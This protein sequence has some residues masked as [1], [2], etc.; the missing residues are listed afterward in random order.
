MGITHV[1]L[2][3]FLTLF[4]LLVLASVVFAQEAATSLQL[5]TP[6][7]GTLSSDNPVDLYIF[8]APDSG[9][10]SLSASSAAVPVGI[11]LTDPFGTTVG[12]VVANNSGEASLVD[13]DVDPGASY[14]V[15]VFSTDTNTGEYTLTL[16]TTDGEN[17]ADTIVDDTSDD[18]S[19]DTGTEE[20]ATAPVGNIVTSLEAPETIQ[21]N[22]GMEVR[23]EWNAAVDLN[24]EV[25]DPNGNTLFFNSRSSAI[26]GSF[27]FDANG[28]CEVISDAPV[29][30]ASW[31]PGFV[32]T[33]SYEILVF[34]R[35]DC[36]ALAQTV[37]FT[38]TVTVNGSVLPAIE[39]T[40]VP[41]TPTSSSVYLSNFIV[42]DASTA[43]LNQGGAYPDSSIQILPATAAELQT[44]AQPINFNTPIQGALF[45]EQDF[46]VYSFE[47]DAND[48]VTI[49]MTA[50]SRNLDTLVQ[51][52]GPGGGIVTV[53]DDSGGSTNSSI[54]N[55]RLN[56]A[57]TYLIVAT[58]YG[59]ELGG[60]EGEYTLNVTE[61]TAALPANLAG[62]DVPQGDIQVYLTWNNNTDLQ[63]L[64]RDPLA[65]AVYDDFP[66]VNSGGLLAANGNVGC[67]VPE[68]G[69]APLSYI[70]W[71][72]GLGRPG[73]YEVDVWFEN[74]CNVTQAPTFTLTV[75]VQGQVVLVETQTPAIGNNFVTNFTI[76]PDG[77]VQAGQAGF[78][79][80]AITPP[81]IEDEE[82]VSIQ[83]NVPLT[84]S[85]NGQN[86]FDV[87]TFDG[88]AGQIVTI[89]MERA[90]GSILDTKV[91]LLSEAG[92]QLSFND[93]APP[94]AFIDVQDRTTDS[95]IGG[96]V[97]PADGTYTI[98][99][100]R[101]ATIFGGTSG[102]YQLSLTVTGGDG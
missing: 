31:A 54:T 88:T 89:A 4:C 14:I 79:I 67:T 72:S 51:L 85:I 26:G 75:V 39:G 76:N 93:D 52:V 97:L 38:L 70:Y 29:E 24:L 32:P 1:V 66:Q 34:Y 41:P 49:N 62:L 53:N 19:D 12:E 59:K 71:P 74:T 35:Q 13:V 56:V 73:T 30:T 46:V 17:P 78:V 58:R 16:S 68:E 91:F 45:E 23:L 81:E 40:I 21:I 20:V 28:L 44:V 22:N 92:I 94:G 27:G 15:T 60:T 3:R 37:P 101:Y 64:V 82:R 69:N 63:L 65:Q 100:S 33:G 95:F 47:A 80:D 98:V 10:I 50:T 55:Q 6:A 57:G 5:D 96:F 48:S 36:E 11:L 25:R 7:S 42:E 43:T 2:R 102:A 87:Y 61:S 86:P 9:V 90:P 83:P 8:S 84:G 99:A 18:T 77:T